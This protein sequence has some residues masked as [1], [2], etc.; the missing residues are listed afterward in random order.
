MWL[1]S[2]SAYSQGSVGAISFAHVLL[3]RVEV[4][5]VTQI[6]G[7]MLRPFIDYSLFCF[8]YARAV[9][10]THIPRRDFPREEKG[11]G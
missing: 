8:T 4:S 11:Y 3:A 6:L 2:D 10:K 1:C 7:E 5:L 9:K